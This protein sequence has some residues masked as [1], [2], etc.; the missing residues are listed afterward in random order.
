VRGD[1]ERHVAEGLR[2]VPQL[3]LPARVVL[4]GEQAQVVP[5]REQPLEPRA[6]LLDAAGER[7]VR[8]EPEATGGA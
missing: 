2:E 3:A 7:I 1:D 4:L 8:S 5:E 6:R